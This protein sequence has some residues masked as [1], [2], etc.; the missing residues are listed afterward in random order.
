MMMIMN[1][2]IEVVDVNCFTV[3]VH[4]STRKD[5]HLGHRFICAASAYYIQ[6]KK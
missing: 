5:F 1:M 6:A 4:V 3:T 2:I